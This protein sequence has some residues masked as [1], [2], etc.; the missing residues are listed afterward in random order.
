ML[1]DQKRSL[2]YSGL[3]TKGEHG[4]FFGPANCWGNFILAGGKLDVCAKM[5]KDCGTAKA[6]LGFMGC[7]SG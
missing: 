2:E 5:W 4:A 6:S 3:G 7:L 1:T